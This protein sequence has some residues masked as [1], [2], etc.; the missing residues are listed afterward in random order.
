MA[1]AFSVDPTASS[2]ASNMPGAGNITVSLPPMAAPAAPVSTSDSASLPLSL[3]S[4][5][6]DDGDLLPA[7]MDCSGVPVVATGI[8]APN[9]ET[10]VGLSA[11]R[12]LFFL[13]T[14]YRTLLFSSGDH[15]G[16]LLAKSFTGTMVEATI[17]KRTV[18]AHHAA[19]HVKRSIGAG[20]AY[21]AT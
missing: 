13:I 1:M 17:P 2:T 9:S 15:F 11:F 16:T 8:S 6:W 7:P 5:V 14:R 21:T 12:V 18:A 4:C 19:R 3:P 10:K 20:T